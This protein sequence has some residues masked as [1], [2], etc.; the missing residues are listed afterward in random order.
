MVDW[1]RRSHRLGLGI[2]APALPEST[3]KN[4]VPLEDIPMEPT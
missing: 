3:G 2:G 4:V 1:G